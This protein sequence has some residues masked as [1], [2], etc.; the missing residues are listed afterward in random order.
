M[1]DNFNEITDS[2][3]KQ[4][5]Y[6]AIPVISYAQLQETVNKWLLII[7]PGFIKLLLAV[8][9]SNRLP[10]DAVWVFLIAPSGGGK[11]EA[12]SAL[13]KCPDYYPL[14]QLTPNTFLSGYKNKE[15]EASLLKRL[16]TGK[17]IGFKDFT[18]LLDGNKDDLKE[19]LGQFRDLYD[20]YVTKVTGT[21]DEIS[22]KGKMGFIAGCTPIIEQRMSTV[23]AMG[24][25]F[26]SYKL[27]HPSRSQLRARMRVNIG[28]EAEMREELQ[29]AFAGYFKGVVVPDV[30]PVIPENVDKTIESMTDFIALSRAVVMRARDA[31]QEI[32]YIVE[33]EM[34]S[35][36]YKQLYTLAMSLII[37][38]GG[39]WKEED[40]YILKRLAI[41]SIHSIRYS[42]IK[43]IMS[44]STQAKTSTIAQELGYPTSTTRRYLE[45]LAAIS[46]NDGDIR[47][48]RREHQGK[49]KPDL[50]NVTQE[51]KAILAG[52]GEVIVATKSDTG[53]LLDEEEIPVGASVP[54]NG[55]A[56]EEV[57][58]YEEVLK[59]PKKFGLL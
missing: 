26:L 52:M 11:T 15:K 44:Y 40:D 4:D 42:I 22:W 55:L 27:T 48:L 56:Q 13:L 50:W 54:G 23:G 46:M 10:S 35:R 1:A 8:I 29:N 45:D 33:P 51:M 12:M 47:I 17:T 19:L 53:F 14:S 31:K 2:R 38:N 34:S 9:I 30:L 3:T 7:D 36:T 41:S 32:E 39:E 20:G 6:N 28:H 43:T 37:M 5:D 16:G 49:G 24:E 58:E 59:E 57:K 25:R 21:G 18:S